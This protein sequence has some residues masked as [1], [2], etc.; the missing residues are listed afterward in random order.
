MIR[1]M[2][3]KQRSIPEVSKVLGITEGLLN[4]KR[5]RG[6]TDDSRVR[7]GYSVAWWYIFGQQCNASGTYSVK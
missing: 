3:Q 5:S 7:F 2:V 1:A 6:G 4:S